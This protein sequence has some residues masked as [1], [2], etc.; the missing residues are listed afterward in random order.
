MMMKHNECNVAILN[1]KI[2]YG[3]KGRATPK[4]YHHTRVYLVTL[5]NQTAPVLLAVVHQA[6]RMCHAPEKM[7]HSHRA[8]LWSYSVT[9][10]NTTYT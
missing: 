3:S 1:T 6:A 9:S 7:F 5:N 2:A 4:W 8:L 10:T